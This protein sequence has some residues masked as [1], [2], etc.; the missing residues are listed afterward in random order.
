MPEETGVIQ[1]EEIS[2]DE[3][4]D[5]LNVEDDDDS[6][7]KVD[8]EEKIDDD[9]KEV[10]DDN[11]KKE[12]EI[13]LSDEEEPEIKVDDDDDQDLVTPVR[14]KEILAKYPKLFKDFPYLEK[15]FYRDRDYTELFGTLE[16]A[17]EVSTKADALDTYQTEL[18][19][20]STESILKAVKE[21]D[22]EAFKKIADNYIETLGRVDQEGYNHVITGMVNKLIGG[23]IAEGKKSENKQLQAAA[24]LV[25][26]FVFGTSDFKPRGKL[27]TDTNEGESKLAREREEFNRQRF[28]TT[29]DDLSSKIGNVLKAT[30]ADNID[31]RD[32][33]TAYVKRQA[34]REAMEDLEGQIEQDDKFS[35]ILDGL[36]KKTSESNYAKK[37]IDRIRSAYLSKAKTLLPAVIKKAKAEALKDLGKRVKTSNSSEERHTERR[38][39]TQ[40]S[41]K[42]SK[43][44][45]GMSTVDF[46][47]Q[48]D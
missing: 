41:T 22:P 46:F 9:K 38:Q 7:K 15:T 40:S 45:R 30:I 2:K 6:G 37:S 8:S 20:G 1:D 29:R 33:M 28:E 13:K 44:G 36:W 10:K 4:L 14:R 39:T 32:S 17:K 27:S 47:N 31:P 18:M 43:D 21:A 48:P 42:T 19:D 12:D 3:I 16:D 25:N 24:Q 5:L 34:V 26:Q 35:K 11:K 23:M